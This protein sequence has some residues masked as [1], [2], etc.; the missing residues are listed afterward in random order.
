MKVLRLVIGM[1]GKL[2]LT[3]SLRIVVTWSVEIF[4][5]VIRAE[6]IGF[7]QIA[8][9]VGAACSPYISTSLGVLGE[10]GPFIVMGG[11]AVIGALLVLLLPETQGKGLVEEVTGI[12]EKIKEK[13]N[14]DA[15]N[16]FQD[17]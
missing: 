3:S 9:R 16:N 2:C 12:P 13:E 7:L 8:S 5:T 11:L 1:T 17:C 10:R 14:I 6:G 15:N 4:P